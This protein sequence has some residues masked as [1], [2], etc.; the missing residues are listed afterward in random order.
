MTDTII[1][2]MAAWLLLAGSAYIAH[3]QDLGLSRAMLI[4]SIRGPIQLILL[5]F[6]LHW[7]FDITAVWMQIILIVSFCLLA[8]QTSASHHTQPKQAWLATSIG[9][10]CGC[11][12]SLPWLAWTG[13][14]DS[15][16]R[17]LIPLASMVAA[18]GMN[19]V[20]MMFERIKQGGNAGDGMRI[21]LIPTVDTLK[22]VGLVHMPGVF[23]GMVLAGSPPMQAAAAQL[24]VL[25][26]IIASSF[27]ACMVT[28]LLMNHWLKR[29]VK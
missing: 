21:A 6:I 5:A 16:S 9:L 28:F 17:A 15:D 3:R 4:A 14:I 11:A 12:V 23:V 19:A 25:Y 22:V 8:A 26:M 10:I 18:N 29:L 7:V 27:T 1:G 20:S 2:L 24:T 13:A